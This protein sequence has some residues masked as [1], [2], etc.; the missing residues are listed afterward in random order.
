M[1]G[2]EA[3]LFDA[4]GTLIHVD[5]ER[6]CRAAGILYRAGRFRAAEG[7]GISAVQE[8]LERKPDSTDAERLPA[9]LDAILTALGL[10]SPA[11]RRE[12]AGRIREEHGR[13]NLWSAPCE[14]A[15]EVL[16]ALRA[17]GYRL[18]LISNADGR[19]RGLLEAAGVAGKLDLILDSAE[20]GME[21]PDARIFRE[22][23]RR[24]GVD[25]GRCAYVGDIY[26]IDV[27]GAEAAGMRAILIGDCPAPGTVTRVKE[28][29]ALL[30]LF[31]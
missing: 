27:A 28:L 5:G 29:S 17:R 24:I 20:V 23:A 18:G 2:V 10:E 7:A 15:G 14:G 8:A 11:T 1:T 25:P 31:P 6:F 22:G 30:E 19:V 13:S 26:E 9:F 21:K 16:D 4:G 12:A 3:I